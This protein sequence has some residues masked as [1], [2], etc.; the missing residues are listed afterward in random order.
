MAALRPCARIALAPSATFASRIG[1]SSRRRT[2]PVLSLRRHGSLTLKH[3]IRA[4]KDAA[5]QPSQPADPEGN[6]EESDKDKPKTVNV[7]EVIA[8]IEEFTKEYAAKLG[9]PYE[10]DMSFE[11]FHEEERKIEENTWEMVSSNSSILHVEATLLSVELCMQAREALHL[12]SML[13]YTASYR[14]RRPSEI[15]M[16]TV[17]QTVR[18]CVS[19]F[20][21]TAEDAYHGKAKRATIRSFLSALGGL[22]AISHILFVNTLD[23]VND[24]LIE[25]DKPKHSPQIDAE[26][27]HRRFEQK[28]GN[29]QQKLKLK[30]LPLKSCKILE[31]VVCPTTVHAKEFVTTMV[32]LRWHALDQVPDKLKWWASD[33]NILEEQRT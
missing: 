4:N 23:T 18:M 16:H 21:K 11:M 19:T 7:E 26:D 27:A 28:L 33:S 10:D 20:V 32:M 8:E 24:L 13:M 3:V 22:A 5:D 9:V 14:L 29:L 30:A 6:D 17:E 31:E 25:E 12:A 2:L 1:S 15:S